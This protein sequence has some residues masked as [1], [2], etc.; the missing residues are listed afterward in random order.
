LYCTTEGQENWAAEAETMAFSA[1][2]E[3]WIRDCIESAVYPS[4]W[5]RLAHWLRYWSLLAIAVTFVLSL[6][7][8]VVTLAVTLSN[9][10]EAEATFRGKAEEKLAGIDGLRSDIRQLRTD[11]DKLGIRLDLKEK[12]EA[13]PQDFG[14]ILPEVASTLKAAADLR[15][16]SPEGLRRSLRQNLLTADEKDTGYW[17]AISQFIVYQSQQGAP[18]ILRAALA[19]GY[20]IEHFQCEDQGAHLT[21][22][23]QAIWRDC[24]L[25]L[26]KELPQGMRE[27]LKLPTVGSSVPVHRQ[28]VCEKCVV[29]YDGGP[30]DPALTN[31][32]FQNSAFLVNVEAR[33]PEQG[34]RLLRAILESPSSVKLPG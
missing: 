10:T 12:A 7:G 3:K 31:S 22:D 6:V 28:F 15:V 20:P 16:P 29:K 23:N 27:T 34:R 8:T 18:E 14:H 1:E 33:P 26:S 11:I 19:G 21:A 2:N 5:K 24:F 9:R 32:V 30:V 13:K 17:P 25:D 4:G